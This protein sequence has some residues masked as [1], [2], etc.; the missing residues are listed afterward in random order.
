MHFHIT[1]PDD[2]KKDSV[3]LADFLLEELETKPEITF[4]V[5]ADTGK[6]H[7]ENIGANKVC[8]GDIYGKNYEDKTFK[9]ERTKE[10]VN[11]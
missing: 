9:D 4:N 2:V 8:L 7:L 11:Y 3:K 10:K 5:W 1:I 6:I